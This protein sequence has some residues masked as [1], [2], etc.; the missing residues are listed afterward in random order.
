MSR[1]LRIEPPAGYVI[2]DVRPAATL[3]MLREGDPPEAFMQ[4]RHE[5][6]AFAPSFLVFPGGRMESADAAARLRARARGLERLGPERAGI[7]IAAIRET[8]EEAGVLFARKPGSDAL[9]D[10]AQVHALAERRRH[11]NRGALG[12]AELIE[13]EDLE[14]AGDLIKPFARWVTPWWHRKRFDT[15]FFVA[16]APEGQ[17]PAHDGGEA[18][19]SIWLKTTPDEIAKAA[20]RMLPPTQRSLQRVRDLGTLDRILSMPEEEAFRAVHPWLERRAEGYVL[21]HEARPGE[22]PIEMVIPRL[23]RVGITKELSDAI[24]RDLTARGWRG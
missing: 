21:L 19:E 5:K 2:S 18:V 8:F 1:A 22:P 4:L 15:H 23:S 3:I 12:F 20:E 11:L 13:A 17:E 10:G 7:V 14:L 16:R 9:I 24:V 6:M